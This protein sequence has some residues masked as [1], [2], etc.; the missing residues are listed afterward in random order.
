MVLCALQVDSVGDGVPKRNTAG[1][2]EWNEAEINTVLELWNKHGRQSEW[3]SISLELAGLNSTGQINPE[4]SAK[5]LQ[6]TNNAVMNKVKELSGIARARR[7]RPR[8]VG[9]FAL[10]PMESGKS[11]P[12]LARQR[13][14]ADASMLLMPDMSR[15][16]HCGRDSCDGLDNDL[17]IGVDGPLMLAGIKSMSVVSPMRICAPPPVLVQAMEPYPIP[18]VPH[19]SPVQY[20]MMHSSPVV[21]Q[22]PSS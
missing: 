18:A 1:V 7:S 12:G 8:T 4:L 13:S 9:N 22:D 10:L 6:R 21:Q 15:L 20:G 14:S 16:G 19:V 5:G 11:S 17:P 3:K 2:P